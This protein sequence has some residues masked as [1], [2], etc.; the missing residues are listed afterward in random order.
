MVRRSLCDRLET[1]HVRTGPGPGLRGLVRSRTSPPARRRAP[2]F[3]NPLADRGPSELGPRAQSLWVLP[4]RA[5]IRS[6]ATLAHF[7]VSSSTSIRLT[8]TP[9]T[10]D[11]IAQTKW[12]RSMRFIVEQ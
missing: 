7:S 5:S 12:G 9:S 6:R 4:G 2:T 3:L 8:T 1:T 10:S 11:S